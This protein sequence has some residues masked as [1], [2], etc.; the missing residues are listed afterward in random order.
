MRGGSVPHTSPSGIDFY[1]DSLTISPPHTAPKGHHMKERAQLSWHPVWSKQIEIWTSKQVQKNLWRFDRVEEFKDVMQDARVLFFT[2]ERKY[3]IV[4]DMRHFFA[5]YRTSLNRMFTDKARLKQKSVIDQNVFLDEIIDALHLEGTP[6]YGHLA[7]LLDELPDEL[8][9]VLQ[10]LTT[11]RVRLKL[12]RPTR[13]MCKREN[14]NMRLK[15]RFSLSMSDPVGELR[16]YFA[17]S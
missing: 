14:F 16:S 6:N 2:L 17:N 12:D 15:R 10:A 13:A 4:N 7:L 3:P 5:L 11:G 1:A 9:T 8:K